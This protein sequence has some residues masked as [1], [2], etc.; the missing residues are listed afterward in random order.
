[1]HQ[2]IPTGDIIHIITA[3]KATRGNEAYTTNHMN[4]QSTAGPGKK[5]IAAPLVRVYSPSEAALDILTSISVPA[6]E[7]VLHSKC[8]D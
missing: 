6:Y 2:F 3:T 1:M 7:A 5:S 8:K 4:Q